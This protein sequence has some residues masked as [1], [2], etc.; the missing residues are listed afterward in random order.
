MEARSERSKEQMKGGTRRAALTGDV[1]QSEAFPRQTVVRVEVDPDVV[2]GGDV[3]R[4]QRGS[5]DPEAV[6][7]PV[8]ADGHPVGGAAMGTL[9]IKVLKATGG[10]TKI[11]RWP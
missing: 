7:A 6:Q 8:A 4:R 1:G 5:A 10:N 2:L 9:K 11:K 3:R